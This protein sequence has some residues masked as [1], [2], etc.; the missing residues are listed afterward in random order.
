VLLL[1]PVALAWPY[2]NIDVQLEKWKP[3]KMPFRAA[4]ISQ[5]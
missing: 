2:E 4:V 3:V 1:I 5:R